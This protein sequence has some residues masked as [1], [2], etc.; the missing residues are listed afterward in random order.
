[1][2][3]R[4]FPKILV[5]HDGSQPA[6]RAF[7]KALILDTRPKN[8]P[9][10]SVLTYLKYRALVSRNAQTSRLLRRR[11]FGRR[12]LMAGPGARNPSI[13]LRHLSRVCSFRR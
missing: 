4:L 8:L 5:A 12:H 3:H 7:A 6:D 10:A 2:A 13:C 1:M 11:R 9:N